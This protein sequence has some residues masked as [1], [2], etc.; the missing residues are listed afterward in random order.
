M[1]QNRLWHYYFGYKKREQKQNNDFILIIDLNLLLRH[2]WKR[3]NNLP[4]FSLKVFFFPVG[5]VT[6]IVEFMMNALAKKLK[7]GHYDKMTH[8]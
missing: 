5:N 7:N 1:F 6:V 8:R 2:L 3:E 4:T